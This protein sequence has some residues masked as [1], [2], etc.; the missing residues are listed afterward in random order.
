VAWGGASALQAVEWYKRGLSNQLF[1]SVWDEEDIEEP[2]LIT[3]KIDVTKLV[4]ATIYSEG[5]KA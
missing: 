3:D 5:E 1:V 2:R 4:E